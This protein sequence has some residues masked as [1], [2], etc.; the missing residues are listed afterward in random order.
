MKCG[1]SMILVLSSD[2][3]S[4]PSPP[5]FPSI[6]TMS[7]LTNVP[8]QWQKKNFNVLVPLPLIDQRYS[9]CDKVLHIIPTLRHSMPLS[10]VKNQAYC[11]KCHV[12]PCSLQPK[13]KQER[14]CSW[15]ATDLYT[16]LMQLAF[17]KRSKAFFT[18]K[19]LLLTFEPL[20]NKTEMWDSPKL[21][22]YCL[23]S[24]F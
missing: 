10:N 14:M 20:F 18:G 3:K 5:L 17:L 11:Q 19:K 6:A 22:N 16:K 21:R 13:Y 23:S 15:L 24:S 2:G 9:V 4:T 7:N 12:F 1:A 8:N